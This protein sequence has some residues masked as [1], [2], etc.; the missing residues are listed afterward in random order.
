MNSCFPW[1]E[2]LTKIAKGWGSCQSDIWACPPSLFK[3]FF[4][5]KP[6]LWPGSPAFGGIAQKKHRR[7]KNS[8]RRSSLASAEWGGPLGRP[9]GRPY[10]GKSQFSE[11]DRLARPGQGMIRAS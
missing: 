5:T 3:S 8:I 4:C 6:S 9:A 2:S 7:E 11:K 1:R 10:I